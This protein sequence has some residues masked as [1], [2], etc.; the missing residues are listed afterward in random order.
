[1]KRRKIHL[2]TPAQRP[3]D[4]GEALCHAHWGGVWPLIV[5]PLSL[6]PH[7]SVD[8]CRCLAG[9]RVLRDGETVAS[10]RRDAATVPISSRLAAAGATS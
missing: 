1:M 6:P 4:E 5:V 9:L 2:G 10:S 7:P 8:C 3:G